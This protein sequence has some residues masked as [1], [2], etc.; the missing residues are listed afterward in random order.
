MQAGAPPAK[1]SLAQMTML[2]CEACWQR[3]WALRIQLHMRLSHICHKRV[4]DWRMA[5]H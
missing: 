3:D 5:W 2:S 1:H 4:G